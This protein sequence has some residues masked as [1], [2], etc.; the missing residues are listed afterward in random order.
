[1]FL[2]DIMS[3]EYEYSGMFTEKD[4]SVKFTEGVST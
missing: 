1:M 4:I 3:E 2:E